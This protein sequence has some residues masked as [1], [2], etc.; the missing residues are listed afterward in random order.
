[1]SER[2]RVMIVIRPTVTGAALHVWHLARRLNR[3]EFEVT[4]VSPTDGWLQERVERA[5]VRHRSL[6]LDREI[7]P[8]RDL[9]AVIKLWRLIRR[10][11]PHILHLHSSKAGF[12]GRI[13]RPF[14]QVAGV[15]YTPHGLVYRHVDG[16][17]RRLYLQLERFAARFG[18]RLICVS[19]SEREYALLDSLGEPEKVAVIHN[20]VE[21]PAKP[22]LGR[23]NL[24]SALQVD[25]SCRIA[26]M[27]SRLERPKQPEDLIQAAAKL[28]ES[29]ARDSFRL[30]FIGDGPLE[31]SAKRMA[32]VLGVEDVVVFL[33]YR[34]DVSTLV[35]DV[36]VAV[37]A[38]RMEGM[39]FSLLEAMAAGKP[40][41]GSDVPGV[42]DLIQQGV[43]GYRFPPGDSVELSS[44]L[45]R[46]F[47]DEGLRRR[48]GAR[49]REIV[50]GG[51]LAENMVVATGELY[52]DLFDGAARNGR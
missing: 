28:A 23:G 8:V 42:A 4:V 27:L 41:V 6:H 20:G 32:R 19:D 38:S 48:L 5:G 46:L 37:L 9:L 35:A 26:A 30:V 13:L 10:E 11:R 29:M 21:L 12:L 24:R 2:I 45:A 33:G 51:H 36:D 7:R 50:A 43:N 1:M 47:E 17:Q 3:A 31:A 39:P 49:G 16:W 34:A 44:L 52:R 25:D 22:D 15:V 14:V 18:D 40:V